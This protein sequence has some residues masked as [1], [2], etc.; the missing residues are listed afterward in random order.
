MS[1]T[2]IYVGSRSL[3]GSGFDENPSSMT[4]NENGDGKIFSQTGTALRRHSPN[5]N[6]RCHL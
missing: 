1:E 6:S 5:E 4:G 2:R 3:R